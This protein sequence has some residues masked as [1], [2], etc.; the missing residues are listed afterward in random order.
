MRI[1]VHKSRVENLLGK[2]AQHFPVHIRQAE[3]RL[4]YSLIVA[5][6]Y[7]MD[8]LGGEDA[9][10][11]QVVAHP[12]HMQVGQVG[13]L[14]AALLRIGRFLFKVQL[15]LQRGAQVG[16]DPLEGELGV[17]DGDHVQHHQHC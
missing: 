1:R 9:A 4:A 13:Q 10:A 12:R 8:E 16:E 17:Q 2:D 7:A 11:R 5:D 3:A 14:A 6:L 15:I